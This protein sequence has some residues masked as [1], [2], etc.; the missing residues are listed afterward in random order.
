M[1]H[2]EVNLEDS[3]EL[4]SASGDYPKNDRLGYKLVLWGVGHFLIW[5]LYKTYSS[6]VTY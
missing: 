4:Q 6:Y 5:Q 2:L 1:V 3:F